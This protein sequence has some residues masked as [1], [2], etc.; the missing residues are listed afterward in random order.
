[1]IP[2]IRESIEKVSNA[3][4]IVGITASESTCAK[5]PYNSFREAQ[6]VINYAKNN[7]RY[8][9]GRRINR[10]VGKK[11]KRPVRSYRCPEC[12]KWHITSQPE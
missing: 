8:V 1:M 9:G 2:D 10:K 5:I 7:R 3:D 4:F 11:D 6:E 12:G